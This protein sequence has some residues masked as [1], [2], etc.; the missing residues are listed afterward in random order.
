MQRKKIRGFEDPRMGCIM[1]LNINKSNSVTN[2]WK[3]YWRRWWEKVLTYV[4]LEMSGA[5]TTKAKETVHKYH[6]SADNVVSHGYM[7]LWFWNYYPYKLKI[8][9]IDTRWW[10]AG[11]SPLERARLQMGNRKIHWCM[12]QWIRAG[13]IGINLCLIKIWTVTHRITYR[14]VCMG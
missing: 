8:H 2:V 11:F 14:Y 1:W 5:H 6:I 9:N 10:E 7:D 13:G 12:W 4:T 3:S